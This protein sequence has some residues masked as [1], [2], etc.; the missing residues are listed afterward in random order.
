MSNSGSQD[1]LM[2]GVFLDLRS[3]HNGDLDLTPLKNSLHEWNLFDHTPEH[4]VL[5]RIGE[6]NV[7]VSNKAALDATTIHQ[8]PR[9]E[10]ICV[11]AT[12]FNNVDLEAAAERGIIVCNVTNYATASV[13]QHVFALILS[14][15]TRLP[16][17]RRAVQQGRWEQSPQFCLLDFPIAELAGKNLG[18]IGYGTLGR[19][20]SQTARAFGMQVLVAA[21]KGQVPGPDRYAFDEVLK[22]ADVLTLHCPLTVDTQALIGVGELRLMKTGAFL[23]NAARGGIV[24]EAA[25]AD[26]LRQGEI[27]GAGIDVLTNEPPSK[28]NPLLAPDIPHLLLTP[29]IAWASR[30]SRQRLL[31]EVARNIAAYQQGQP[32]N[33]VSC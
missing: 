26:A 28:G 7:V 19:A 14:L 4:Q 27:A 6:A 3:V 8:A 29:H 11:A 31:E 24:D 17:Y 30:E 32:R 22:K 16:E 5:K 25:L 21:H 9:L 2:R 12:G 15:A 13:V 33:V 10:L 18:V 1:K 20:V 23:I